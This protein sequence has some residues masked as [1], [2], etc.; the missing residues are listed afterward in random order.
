MPRAGE[1][2]DFLQSIMG[3]LE[4]RLAD[5]HGRKGGG[6]AD[7]DTAGDLRDTESVC[8]SQSAD[9]EAKKQFEALTAEYE[10][11][12]SRR[13]HA[14]II[15]KLAKVAIEHNSEISQLFTSVTG[16]GITGAT[17]AAGTV[18]D[19]QETEDYSFDDDGT[20]T[21]PYD[22]NGDEIPDQ[23]GLEVD[24]TGE[25]L[26]EFEDLDQEDN[27]SVIFQAISDFFG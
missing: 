23:E 7:Q 21:F 9:L 10:K 1:Q 12:Q 8:P 14:R 17:P 4:A 24:E 26:G 6:V 15:F 22:A 16:L 20:P 18:V 27:I 11:T 3:N 25:E 13:Q 5:R 19:D 2:K